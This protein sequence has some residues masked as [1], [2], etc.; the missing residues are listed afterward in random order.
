MQAVVLAAGLGTRLRPV[1]ANRSKAMVPVLGRPLVERALIPFLENGV[2]DF[3]FVISPDDT[4]IT[5]HFTEHT[6]LDLTSRFVVQT[7]R[8]GTAH[9]LGIAAPFVS[10]R[11]AVTACDSLV[12]ASHVRALLGEQDSSDAVLSL[13][14]VEPELV[15]RSASVSLDGYAVRRI[16]EKPALEEAP[17]LTVSLPHYIFSPWLLDLLPGLEASSRGEFEIPDAIQELIDAGR[18]V[19]GVR[20]KERLQVSSS[21]DLLKLTRKMFSS[22]PEPTKIDLTALGSGITVVEPVRIERDVVVGDGSEIGPAVFLESGCLIGR[23]AVVR[24]SIVLRGGRV[25]DGETIEDQVVV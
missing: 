18:Q 6:S 24:R 2:R 16:V 5:R 20:A 22:D 8:L 19:V 4:E 10:G 21:E 25:D 3:V 14:D 11:F 17:S 7:E 1:T 9:A 15:S 23:G 13:L 12:D